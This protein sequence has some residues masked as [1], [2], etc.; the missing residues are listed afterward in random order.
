MSTPEVATRGPSDFPH[1]SE[2][3]FGNRKH[4][5]VTLVIEKFWKVDMEI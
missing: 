5:E 3:I 1:F 2:N 4:R